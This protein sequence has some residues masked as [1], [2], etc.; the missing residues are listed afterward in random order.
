MNINS[1]LFSPEIFD[2]SVALAVTPT[3][4]G[5][6][7]VSNLLASI[8]AC[9]RAWPGNRYKMVIHEN[10][11][12]NLLKELFDIKADSAETTNIIERFPDIAKRMEEEMKDWQFSV[13]ESLTGK[14][15]Q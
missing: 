1:I 3:S 12:G 9:P 2:P 13:L 7:A 8:V 5:R 4:P 11:D 10:K 6:I 15:Y 14:D